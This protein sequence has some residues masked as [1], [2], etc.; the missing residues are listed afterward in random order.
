MVGVGASSFSGPTELGTVD[1][2]EADADAN[3]AD[4]GE[5]D[6]INLNVIYAIMK[7]DM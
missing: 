7:L 3:R 1:A 6:I 5:E 2:E 4:S